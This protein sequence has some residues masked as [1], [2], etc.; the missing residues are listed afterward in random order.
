MANGNT[1]GFLNFGIDGDN[2]ELLKK[3][4]QA[5]KEALSIEQI[6]K[7]INLSPN[8]TSL[9]GDVLKASIA[10]DKLSISQNKVNQSAI[11]ALKAEQQL[12]TSITNG[13]TAKAR[14]VVIENQRQAALQ[15]SLLYAKQGEAVS[16]ES[17]RKEILHKQKLL[18]EEERLSGMRKRN[19][20]IG[21][22]G[23]KDLASAYGLTNKTMFN[24]YNLLQQL[25][26][27][28][29][30]Y[31]SVYQAGSFLKELANVSGEF[32]KQRVSLSAIIGNAK[33]ASRIFNQ[34]KGLAIISPFN[35]KELADYAKQLAAFSI[36]TSEIYETTTRLADLSAGLGVDMSRIILAYG[37]V[38]SAAVLRGQELRQFTEAG[39]PMVDQLA[40]KFSELSGEVVTAGDVFSKIS[41]KEVPFEMVKEVIQ[42]LTNEGGMFYK[43]QE[44]QSATLAGKISNLRDNYDMLLDSIGRSNKGLLHGTLDGLVEIMDNWESYWR[45]LKSIIVTYGLY[46]A[47]L[48]IIG[49]MQKYEGENIIKN[50]LALK[51]E[52]AAR[53]RQISLSRELTAQEQLRLVNVNN[54]T[55]ADLRSLVVT[56]QLN[57]EM[58]LRMVTTK[59][60]TVEQAEYLKSLL[61]MTSAEISHAASMSR[62]GA[63]AAYAKSA[64]IG[65]GTSLKALAL[66]PSTWIFA[67]IGGIMYA[68]Q[69]WND[70]YSKLEDTT[71]EATNTFLS[72][73][74]K[75][76]KF[77]LTESPKIKVAIDVGSDEDIKKEIQ[78]LKNKLQDYGSLGLNIIAQAEGGID[79]TGKEV[80]GIDNAT[81]KLKFYHAAL[82]D[83]ESAYKEVVRYPSLFIDAN[84][85]LG[86]IIKDNLSDVLQGLDK[87]QTDYDKKTSDVNRLSG[88]YLDLAKDLIAS[89]KA[90]GDFASSLQEIIDKGGTAAEVLS[91][92]KEHNPFFMTT[93]GLRPK[94]LSEKDW[95]SVSMWV[96]STN[97]LERA[98]KAYKEKLDE[99][100]FDI[101]SRNEFKDVDW[102]K[103]LDRN[104]EMRIRFYADNYIA[105]LDKVSDR[106]KQELA[107]KTIP[108]NFNFVPHDNLSEFEGKVSTLQKN[109]DLIYNG[110]KNNYGVEASKVRPSTDNTLFDYID[111]LNKKNKTDLQ[112][113]EQI[114]SVLKSDKISPEY[115]KELRSDLN[116]LESMTKIRKEILANLGQLPKSE[117]KGVQKD[118]LLEK[119][120]KRVDL[121]KEVRSEFEKLKRTG[122]TDDESAAYI[123]GFDSFKNIDPRNYEQ[124]INNIIDKIKKNGNLTA[125]R[126]SF[127]E[128]LLFGKD[129]DEIGRHIEQVTKEAKDAFDKIQKELSQH[130]KQYSLY[131]YLFGKTGDKEQSLKIAFGNIH[132][133]LKT[134]KDKLIEAINKTSNEDNKKK[135]QEDLDKLNFDE[136]SSLAKKMSDLISK[137]QS[138][139]E[140]ITAIK[141]QYAEERKKISESEYDENFKQASLDA[142]ISEETDL[143]NKLK[144][145]LFTLTDYYKKIFGDLSDVT[146]TKLKEMVEK[147]ERI[148]KNAKAKVDPKTNKVLGYELDDNQ[149]LPTNSFQGFF[150]KI[151]LL[152]KEIN[153]QDPFSALGA[154]IKKLKTDDAYSLSDFAK[155]TTTNLKDIMDIAN[156]VGKSLSEMFAALGDDEAAENIDYILNL[157]NALTKMASDLASG[158]VVQQVTG[159]VKGIASIITAIA[160]HHDNKLNQSI[161]RYQ[162]E[163]KK[164]S[165]ASSEIERIVSRQLGATTKS[166][167]DSLVKNQE[168][169]IKSL[170]KQRAAEL[171]KKKS[172]KSVVA[173]LDNQIAEAKDK[174]RYFYEDL[175]GEQWGIKIQDWA[176]QIS[177]ALVNAFASG[178][179]AANAFDK[180]VADIM[181]SVINNMLKLNI[182]EPAM[183][184]LRTKLFGE[185]GKSGLL[186]GG[187]V[188][189]TDEIATEIVSE[190]M[191]LKDKIAVGKE[192]W[193]K[194]NEASGGILSETE[195]KN[196]LTKAE[197]SLTESTGN[198]LAS[199]MNAMRADLSEQ[200]RYIQQLVVF[201]QLNTGLVENMY[202][203]LMRV[204]VNTLATANNTARNLELVSEIRSLLQRAT[205]AGTGVKFNI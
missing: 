26:S 185:D 61:G 65:L 92:L 23:Q 8:G 190:L 88:I 127:I 37:Q 201:A 44:I 83:I 169:Q 70:Y 48:A 167:A 63:T 45:V 64:I 104:T 51:A 14:G 110:L 141:K 32:E 122:K 106:L 202:A 36:P 17:A 40:K 67:A 27:A 174:L 119:L 101:K 25:S 85:K 82:K 3:L 31:L 157:G 52:E 42:D 53:L 186:A 28:A 115:R 100:V 29:G 49:S 145:E 47:H 7:N 120:K 80:K 194:L 151:I 13:N 205:T 192:I 46:R 6:F 89:G 193:D 54:I 161:K 41:N 135:L 34:I 162:I 77:L 171:K 183:K 19:A 116:E 2:K 9:S 12:E 55:E 156:D 112:K 129:K 166:Q 57:K 76:Q 113:I 39:I 86:G 108:V 73:Y 69:T 94:E 60:L 5:K 176:G 144:E 138:T 84:D 130:S 180:S 197:Q 24:Q 87:A 124:E 173:D 189:M 142:L 199:Y 136:T 170:E 71:R 179:D 195:S 93:H 159:T 107:E 191:K 150:Q 68:L 121:L 128:S 133:Q 165:N 143:I 18:I 15:K 187:N 74:S 181:K 172:D 168:E 118:I 50:T 56:G 16:A 137:H 43:M 22:Q 96:I 203:E 11:N 126:E 59:R 198:I 98:Q 184:E 114:K 131:E 149:F 75:I 58:V 81:E 78:K 102:N 117:D 177:S 90:S 95:G 97:Q 123:M 103:P 163:F 154:N 125:D 158:N 204:Q 139:E 62:L 4:E 33:E 66:N 21:V 152:R 155:E 134:Q 38:R 164:L 175:A 20:L 200:K 132:E 105:S 148:I 146:F 10:A 91:K 147:G 182:I 79:D 30:I 72:E 1:I 109:I 140:K 111:E 153:K 178:E 160:N 188:K 35:F 196:T 99:F